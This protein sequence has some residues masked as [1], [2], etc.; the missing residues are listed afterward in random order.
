MAQK[1]H[2]QKNYINAGIENLRRKG[3]RIV[4]EG[5]PMLPAASLMKA[6]GVIGSLQGLKKPYVTIVNSYTTHIPGH[7]H[8]DVLGE[9]LRRELKRLGF[10]VWYANVG[11]AICDGIAMGHY[12]MKYLCRPVS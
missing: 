9:V 3:S 11:A 8:L 12:G 4:A 6:A 7:A 2:K 10:N 1:R 5:S